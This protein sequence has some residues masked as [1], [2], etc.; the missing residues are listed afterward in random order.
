[1]K[2]NER[3]V[4]EPTYRTGTLNGTGNDYSIHFVLLQQINAFTNFTLVIK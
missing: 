2:S 4:T 1:M 3:N